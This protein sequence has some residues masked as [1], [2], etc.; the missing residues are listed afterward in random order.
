[1][2][3]GLP[4]WQWLALLGLVL[5]SPIVGLVAGGV[6]TWLLPTVLV[7]GGTVTLAFSLLRPPG[8][9]GV[10]VEGSDLVVRPGGPDRTW[11]MASEIRVPLDAVRHV[12]VRDPRTVGRGL[13]LPGTELPTRIIAGF[14]GLG[15]NRAFWL[16][17]RAREVVV[18]ELEGTPLARIVVEVDDPPAVATTIRRAS[19][20]TTAP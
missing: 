16:V 1:M 3:T 14:Y 19:P 17:K 18:V 4:T 11:A 15:R 13:R 12:D 20:R 7:G 8:P 10:G 2:R 9:P 5:A 6:A